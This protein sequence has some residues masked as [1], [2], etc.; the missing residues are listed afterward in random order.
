ALRV[1]GVE[2]DRTLVV[3]EHGEIQAVDIRNVLQLTAG[4][5]A[6]AGALDLDHV[7]T[8]PGQ[9][10]GAGRSRLDVGEIENANVRQRLGHLFSPSTKYGR[11][12]R[13]GFPAFAGMTAV[14]YP[15]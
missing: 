4:D 2:R 5:V 3:V 11:H 1:L 12:A 10:L 7:G 13:T 15:F 9:Q 8:E 6:D 14:D